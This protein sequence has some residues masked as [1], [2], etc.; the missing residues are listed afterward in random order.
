MEDA[1]K[2]LQNYE[3]R[4]ILQELARR[5]A[6]GQHELAHAFALAVPQ[7]EASAMVLH[8]VHELLRD[9]DTAH[10]RMAKVRVLLADLQ[11]KLDKDKPDQVNAAMQFV[12]GR[13]AALHRITRSPAGVLQSDGRYDAQAVRKTSPAYSGWVVGSGRRSP[14][15]DWPSACGKPSMRFWNI[16][17]PTAHRTAESL[18]EV[19]GLDGVTTDIMLKLIRNLPPVIDTVEMR[20]AAAATLQ[21]AGRDSETRPTYAA[22]VPPEYDW[23]HSYPMIVALHGTD[24]SAKAELEWWAGTTENPGLAQKRGYIVI[25]PEYMEEGQRSYNYSVTAHDA[26][27]RAIVDARKRFTVDSDRVFLTGHGTG[28]DAAFDIGMSHPDLFAGVVPINGLCDGACKWYTQNAIHTQWYVITG[29][30]DGAIHST[31]MRRHWLASWGNRRTSCWSNS[32]SAATNRITKR[33]RGFLTG[34]RAFVGKSLHASSAC[35]YCVP[36][37]AGF[38]GCRPMVFR[39]PSCSRHSWPVRLTEMSNR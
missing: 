33:D 34:W 32:R 1:R 28:G 31:Q 30:F 14:I 17:E 26:V 18:T 39:N 29:E 6:A 2:E 27:L 11:A 3:H 7:N 23:R 9:Y 22:I 12:G 38:I 25:V 5:K 19:S 24:H 21:V 20:P 10:D 15:W 37:K 8:D 4:L 36:A 13:R 35:R 16:S